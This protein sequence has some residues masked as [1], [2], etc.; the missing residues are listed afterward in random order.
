M[1]YFIFLSQ[2]DINPR[3]CLWE[4]REG[5]HA[6][7]QGAGTW[8]LQGRREA[9]GSGEGHVCFSVS[10]HWLA[11]VIADGGGQER[12]TGARCEVVSPAHLEEELGVN[13]RPPPG[14]I[15][16]EAVCLFEVGVSRVGSAPLRRRRTVDPSVKWIIRSALSD[17][18]DGALRISTILLCECAC[19]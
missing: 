4:S 3:R 18:T 2:E 11:D 5:E 17:L 8:A 19:V 12:R 16:G 7:K 9:A 14:H 10:K 6:G 15:L 13:G 1:F